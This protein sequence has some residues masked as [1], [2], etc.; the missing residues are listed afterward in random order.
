MTDQART[1]TGLAQPQQ[2][3]AERARWWQAAMGSDRV[4]LGAHIGSLALGAIL[5]LWL[6]RHMWFLYDEW[7]FFAII[8]PAAERGDWVHFLFAPYLN[9]WVTIPNLT[10][11]AVYHVAGARLYSLYLV[12]VVAA[13]LSVV[14][15]VRAI[16]RRAG[17]GAWAA[18]LLSLIILL[19]GPGVG[20]VT[21]GWQIEFLGSMAFGLAQL[22]ISDHD[23]PPDWRD[24]LGVVCGL[25]GLMCSGVALAL[26]ALVG[27]NLGLRGRWRAAVLAVAPLAAVYVVWYV[28]IGHAGAP[29]QTPAQLA[30]LP[31]FVWAGVAAT[32]DGML[33]LKGVAGVILLAAIYLLVRSRVDLRAPGLSLVGAMAAAGVLF[34]AIT[35]LGRVQGGVDY[36]TQSRYLYVGTV[37]LMPLLG[38]L[39]C[40]FVLTP[41]LMPVVAGALIW[42]TVANVGAMYASIHQ[43][44]LHA[45][46]L[47]QYVQRLAASPDLDAA[48]PRQ[49]VTLWGATYVTFGLVR[50]LRDQGQLP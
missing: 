50:Q 39:V 2:P 14:A 16:L 22:L 21:F 49:A 4:A 5:I 38:V 26:V 42:I 1:A 9:H 17:V 6:D 47:R 3:A 13:H 28:A 12:P 10:W 41:R 45:M 29:H 24:A 34:F 32:L 30:L 48:D 25:L 31:Q 43:E 11:E 8:H 27:I 36:A 44:S 18:T 37:L 33:A 35:G 20:L 46:D 23:G 40:R 15:M 19:P 7:A